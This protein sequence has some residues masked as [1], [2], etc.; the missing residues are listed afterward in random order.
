ML[1][2]WRRRGE[3]ISLRSLIRLGILITGELL[4]VFS[5]TTRAQANAH[6]SG[7]DAGMT[8]IWSLCVLICCVWLFSIPELISLV[9]SIPRYEDTHMIIPKSGK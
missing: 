7:R 1:L 3:M 4:I 6:F 8:L 9:R 5:R 2:L